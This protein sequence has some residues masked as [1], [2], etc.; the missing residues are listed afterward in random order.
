MLAVT[1]FVP[2]VEQSDTAV[3]G[4]RLLGSTYPF[5]L[6]LAALALIARFGLSE[7]E[8]RLARA[9]AEARLAETP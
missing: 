3:F 9:R 6:H 5:V 7:E 8:H 4:M 1:G 2:N